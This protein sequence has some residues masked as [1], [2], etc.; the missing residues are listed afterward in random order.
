MADSSASAL[1]RTFLGF[2]EYVAQQ[3]SLGPILYVPFLATVVVFS[4]PCSPL[5]MVPG[6]LFG[7][8]T[9]VCVSIV[10]KLLGNFV[11]ITLV[12]V[13]FREWALRY[14]AQVKVFRVVQILVKRGV[15]VPI[16]L[17][18]L[19]PLPYAVKNYGLAVLDVPLLHINFCAF[20]TAI[21]FACLWNYIG[22]ESKNL[23]QIFE[24]QAGSSASSVIPEGIRI[25][26]Y[27]AGALFCAGVAYWA[28]TE[29]LRALV[30]IKEEDDEKLRVARETKKER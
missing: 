4:I 12:R 9:G 11:C 23:M 20:V 28:R 1:T 17:I 14:L 13:Y 24:G 8:K 10:G 3:G 29:W 21:P 5:E 27:C 6:F 30:Q 16:L 25:P 7:F 26:I 2:S 15:I 22:S 18:R 19:F